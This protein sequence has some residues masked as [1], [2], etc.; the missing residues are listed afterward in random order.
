M[1]ITYYLGAGASFNAIPIWDEQG[2]SMIDLAN[3]V[4][5][6]IN[7]RQKLLNEDE[8][9]FKDL[10]DDK[11]LVDFFDKMAKYGEI[12]IKYGSIDI[13]AKRLNLLDEKNEL[14]TLKK[15]LSV[16]FDLWESG[17]INIKRTNNGNIDKI[18]SYDII[19]KRYLS[20][21][22]ILLKKDRNAP[23]LNENIKFITWNYDLQLEHAYK[24]FLS[25]VDKNITLQS[26]DNSLRFLESSYSHKNREI[27]HLNGH[28]GMF[29]FDAKTYETVE[30]QS[31]KCLL[32]Y[33]K[34]LLS[35][36]DFEKGRKKLDYSSFIKYGWES[37]SLEH[38]NAAK[39]IMLKTNVLVIIGYSFP[40]FNRKIDLELI[41][42]FESNG[43]ANKKVIYQDPNASM[44]I[45]KALFNNW[46]IVEI[47]KEVN[48]QF[49]IP[50]EFLS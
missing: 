48:N 9:K 13:Y 8:G 19:D 18:Q 21:L 22:S 15:S 2:Q 30:Q 40:A 23:K 3:R 41:R 38:L 4:K 6:A 29:K 14:N 32:S 16:Y 45:I 5:G 35:N 37:P 42:V 33:L 25:E 7:D 20:L 46:R 44:D 12:A 11:T 50:D 1:K 34:G 47:K 10:I 17:W 28:R 24:S 36:Q 39:E 43:L 49:H 27:I 31:Q 26:L